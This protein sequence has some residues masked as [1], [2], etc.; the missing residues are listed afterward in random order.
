MKPGNQMVAMKMLQMGK[1]GKESDPPKGSAMARMVKL[2]MA[3]KKK[4][5]GK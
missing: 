1:G 2:R 3:L 5:G 4:K